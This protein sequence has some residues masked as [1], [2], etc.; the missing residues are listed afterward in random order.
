LLQ[1]ALSYVVSNRGGGELV[2]ASWISPPFGIILGYGVYSRKDA[3]MLAER[4]KHERWG[5]PRFGSVYDV[6]R[7]EER[8]AR[9]SS[10]SKSGILAC[11]S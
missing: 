8:I 9:L 7:L 5:F 11:K 6:K 4:S 1:K 3:E 2:I 10:P